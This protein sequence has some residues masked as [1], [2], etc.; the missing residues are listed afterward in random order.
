MFIEVLLIHV[1][2]INLPWYYSEQR[3]T[4][5]IVKTDTYHVNKEMS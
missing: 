3:A 4:V 5:F 1:T 2:D